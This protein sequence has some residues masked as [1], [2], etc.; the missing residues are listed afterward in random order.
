MGETETPVGSAGPRDL[1]AVDQGGDAELTAP[2]GDGRAGRRRL[3]VGSFAAGG[4]L[5]FFALVLLAGRRMGVV[6]GPRRPR[7]RRPRVDWVDGPAY[8]DAVGSEPIR[9][10]FD[11]PHLIAL[12]TVT[13]VLAVLAAHAFDRRDIPP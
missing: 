6:E 10:G 7:R 12:T 1:V 3:L 4:I 13:A 5:C 11:A 9:N 8:R 2:L